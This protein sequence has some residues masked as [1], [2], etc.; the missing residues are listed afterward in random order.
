MHGNAKSPVELREALEA[1]VGHVVLDSVDEIERLAAIAHA[2]LPSGR[3]QDVLIRVTPGVAGDTHAAISTG[4][5]DSKF[6]FSVE[7]AREA[8][9]ALRGH[10]SL[11]LVGLH[12]H[13]GSQLF[14]LEPFRAAVRAIAELGDFPVY[15]LGGGLGAA[16]TPDQHPPSIER[17]V[18]T[19]VAALHSELGEDKRL[20]LEARAGPGR[21]L[22]GDAVHGADGQAQRLDLGRGRR[23]HV[24]QPAP[25]VVRRPLRGR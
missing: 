21:Q 8:I 5:A 12:F 13:I 24:G 1:G 19:I 25:D 22:H 3:R 17:Y 15:N 10:R 4:Q 11:E 2:T 9:V 23:R 7:Q 18:E 6:G 20:L 14:E 16:Y